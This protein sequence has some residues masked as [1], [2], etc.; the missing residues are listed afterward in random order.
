[1][2]EYVKVWYIWGKRR[3]CCWGERHNS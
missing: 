2:E 1:M 3:P